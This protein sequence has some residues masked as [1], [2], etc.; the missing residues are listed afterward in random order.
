MDGVGGRLQR[1]GLALAVGLVA[2]DELGLDGGALLGVGLGLGV[3]GRVAA[4]ALHG[5]AQGACGGV[6]REEHL[7]L[8]VGEDDRADVAALGHDVA[9]LGCLALD[10]EHGG[11]HL[12]HGRDGAD[13]GVHL[14]RADLGG[15]VLAVDEH[16]GALGGVY[17]ADVELVGQL[18]HRDGVVDVEATGNRG[19]GDGAV[20]RARVEVGEV[21][22]LGHG[23][24]DGGLAGARGAVDGDDHAVPFVG[25]LV[26]WDAAYSA[27]Q[28]SALTESL[29]TKP[30]WAR[31]SSSSGVR[32]AVC[33]ESLSP[34]ETKTWEDTLG[35]MWFQN[36]ST[37]SW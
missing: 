30:A 14:G 12:G 27:T 11:S 9:R 7:D 15:A 28:A 6:G 36:R 1:G 2:G 19:V 29:G 13:V 8:G 18:A 23:A 31:P 5:A 21:G 10:R 4:V 17:E 35:T 33:N 34:F 16:D 20:H 22:A 24:G 3:G 26:G 25:F 37:G 32:P